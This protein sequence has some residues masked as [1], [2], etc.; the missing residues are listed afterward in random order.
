V[1]GVR[2]D[3]AGR[4][5]SEETTRASWEMDWGVLQLVKRKASVRE[6]LCA[7]RLEEDGLRA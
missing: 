1:G 4:G 5:R 3:R 6:A 7:S 2:P